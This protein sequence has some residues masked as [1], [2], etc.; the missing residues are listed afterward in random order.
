M[1]FDLVLIYKS[2]DNGETYDFYRMALALEMANSENKLI[3]DEFNGEN[4]ENFSM[5]VSTN[6]LLFSNNGIK[7]LI[8]EPQKV[9]DSLKDYATYLLPYRDTI[10]IISDLEVD[11]RFPEDE[12]KLNV[13]LSIANST[14]F[15]REKCSN[16]FSFSR[17]KLKKLSTA[18]EARKMIF[19]KIANMNNL[20]QNEIT[21]D[22]S[23]SKKIIEKNDFHSEELANN[24]KEENLYNLPDLNE[25]I[26][27]IK[28]KIVGQ[29]E[30]IASVVSNIYANQI[31][32]KK[33]D[34]SKLTSSKVSILIDGATGTGKTA[35]IKETTDQLKLPI[36]I[37]NSSDFSAIG[38]VGSS[39]TDVLTKLLEQTHGD[40]ELAQKGI[41]CIDE[42]DKLGGYDIDREKAMK[43]VVQEEL[44][45]YIGGSKIN[46]PISKGSYRTI[47][48]DTSY[49]TFIGLGA[50]MDIRD[51][52]NKI[53][54]KK[55][56]GF[57]QS[58]TNNLENNYVI[59]EQDYLEYGFKREFL[60]RFLLR[61]S[62]KSYNV[63]DYKNILLNSSISPLKVFE[64]FVKLFNVKEVTYDDNFIDYI[65]EKAYKLG[66]GVRGLQKIF[67][68]LKNHMLI[69]ILNKKK[70]SIHLTKEIVINLENNNIKRY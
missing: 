19:G 62:T 55:S 28:T 66:F 12:L 58:L 68:D 32:I 37:C 43:N 1:D 3:C 9:N 34:K 52:K 31:L 20:S 27:Q 64:E 38:Y 60:G 15:K 36:V 46:V 8:Y 13:I 59:T 70:D 41:I 2:N 24:Y 49:L 47:E 51:K 30:A 45:T 21:N 57:N 53:N 56:I 42:I 23:E 50:F 6:N 29:D 26:E 14:S 17:R 22:Y 69:D 10:K 7:V 5:I 25:L 18:E 61:T 54:N 16:I 39:L 65:S 44:L 4:L 48:F 35:I 63:S 33:M 40:L 11:E 67:S